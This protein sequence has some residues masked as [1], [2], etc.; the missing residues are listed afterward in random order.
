MASGVD[1]IGQP[2][3]FR[4]S[5]G[6]EHDIRAFGSKQPGSRRSDS[7]AC[8]GNDDG[9]VGEFHIRLLLF[10]RACLGARNTP[11]HPIPAGAATV[12]WAW[13]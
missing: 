8:A 7:A 4:R 13:P 11:G 5:A 1:V 9:F 2:A 10:D 12:E 6:S 3:Q